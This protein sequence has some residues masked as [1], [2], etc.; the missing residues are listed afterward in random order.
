MAL[1]KTITTPNGA[2]CEYHRVDS[3]AL[4]FSTL[5]GGFTVG[6]YETEAMAKAIRSPQWKTDYTGF[7]ATSFSTAHAEAYAFLKTLPEFSGAVD[8]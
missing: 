3:V 7:T 5:H 2:V 4:D 1:I 8:C 6:N